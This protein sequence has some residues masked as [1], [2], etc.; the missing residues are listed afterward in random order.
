MAEPSA[1]Q[2][3]DKDAIIYREA[4]QRQEAEIRAVPDSE[5]ATPNVE[6][7]Q[8]LT[9][10]LQGYP[11]IL[12]LRPKLIKMFTDFDPKAL[13][14][15]A[16]YA[17][18]HLHCTTVD[19]ASVPQTSP[20]GALLEEGTKLCDALGADLNAA[21][22]R[23]TINGAPLKASK[24]TAG[25][26]NVA[27]TLLL[28]AEVAHANWPKLEGKTHLTQ[29]E[30]RHAEA[31]AARINTFLADRAREEGM[32]SDA[33][34]QSQRAFTLFF[35]AFQSV[36][37]DVGYVLDREGKAD[38][39]DE[40]MPSIHNGRGPAKKRPEVA[41]TS[42]QPANATAA[43]SSTAPAAPLGA[44]PGTGGRVGMPDSDPFTAS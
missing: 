8:A 35:R 42:A 37:R 20:G 21:A 14:N 16:D 6:A 27:D 15:L 29:A 25:Y 11:S 10:T 12:A 9:T 2:V 13:D 43:A 18:A 36:R 28:Y 40:I 3:S 19:K 32:K 30:L 44:F 4:Y 22:Q 1:V 33:E 38:Q 39:L 23:G 7:Q 5:L 34:L 26:R 24:G 31:L 17:M 41:A